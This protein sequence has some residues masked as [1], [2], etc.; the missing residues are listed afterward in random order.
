[1]ADFTS[2]YNAKLDTCFYLLTVSQSTH[3]TEPSGAKASTVRKMLF[4][5]NERE[6]YGEYLGPVTF[7]SPTVSFPATCS[8]A[9]IYCA[10]SREW[11]VL[12]EPYMEK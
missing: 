10:S 5:I 3:G 8:V 2:H 12:V 7:E 9:G 11:D 4:D 1:M 6:L